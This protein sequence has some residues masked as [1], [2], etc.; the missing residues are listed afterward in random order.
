M[1][2]DDSVLLELQ[3]ATHATLHTIGT[4]LAGL[5]LTAAEINALANLA[6]G[7]ARTMSEL[8]AA[9]G[10]RPS[11]LTSVLDRLERRGLVVRGKRPGDRRAV[12]V[13]LTPDGQDAART[14]ARTFTGLER[15]ALAGLPPG[16]VDGFRAVLRALAEAGR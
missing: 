6:D 7:R 4:E 16:A 10:T 11:T 14:V 1:K 15:R 9:V 5:G 13:E 3:R 2:P 8:A 12:S